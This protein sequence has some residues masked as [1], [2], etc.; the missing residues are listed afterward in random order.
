MRHSR[1]FRAAAICALALPVSLPTLANGT[2]APVSPKRRS[3]QTSVVAPV[4][5]KRML[6]DV[7]TAIEGMRNRGGVRHVRVRE[8]GRV[9]ALYGDLGA[10]PSTASKAAED[11]AI[12]FVG[13]IAP[14][15]GTTDAAR[16]LRLE[17]RIE[18][19]MGETVRLAQVAGAYRVFDSTTSV[20][21]SRDGEVFGLTS[22][23]APGVDPS[24]ADAHPAVD[25]ATA[26]EVALR[27]L[28][29]TPDRL[30]TNDEFTAELGIAPVDSGR[31]AWR[32]IVPSREPFD[33]WQVFVDAWT[34][35]II[36]TPQSL[37]VSAGTAKVFVPNAVVSTGTTSLRDDSNA[38]SAVPESAYSTVTLQGL[39]ASGFVTGPFC[40]TD[41]TQ[42]RTNKAN[43]DFTSLRRS[44]RGFNEVEA[45]W[46]IDAA[47]RYIQ[48]ALG[49][50]AAANYQLKV[51]VHA[52][53]ADNSNYTP[54]GGGR[55]VL[56]FGDGGVDDAQDA[57]IVWHEYGH[58]ILDNQAQIRLATG[59]AGA[60]H[61][62]WGDYVAATMSQT[63]PGD[64]RFHATIG[65]WDA[66][67]YNPGN[68]P[69]LRRVDG[70]KKYPQDIDG[71][72]H[73]D[74]EIWSACL[75]GINQ[76]IGRAKADPIIFN[77]NFLFPFDVGFEDAA[78]AVLEADG[79]LN[80]GANSAAIA[81]VFAAR[82][83][84]VVATTPS[85]SGVRIKKSKLVVDGANFEIGTA[86]VEIDGAT[87]SA[88]KYPAA[89]RENGVSLRIVSKDSRVRTLPRGV[90]VQVTVLNAS[91]GVRSAAFTFTP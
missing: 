42:S 33:Q 91:S 30:R 29:L 49:I 18:T 28:S 35:E 31:L 90:P 1:F 56:N 25:E 7:S 23:F 87:Y 69:F 58:A 70:A 8:N 19:P 40:S 12:A 51:D 43:G 24:L 17:Q 76:A 77:A 59:E 63:V 74:G 39:D 13:E 88:L 79:Q 41:R 66:V 44:D 50:N 46:A 54:T 22:S 67:S 84:K 3:A 64:S 45:Y 26:R 9:S 37:V 75:W 15:V 89:F 61:E 32:L 27:T 71:E 11:R 81:A 48:N 55:G 65:E 85:V 16:E 2:D 60:I 82:G 6:D 20:H 47:Q 5:A 52:F 86:L 14:L 21:V 36:G 57:E 78:L 68:P 10:L 34:S 53:S 83:I 72:V 73:D 62:G 38:N 4:T 80:G